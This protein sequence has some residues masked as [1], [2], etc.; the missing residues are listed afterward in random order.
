MVI[1]VVH[2]LAGSAAA[3]L[4][5]LAIIPEPIWAI[6]YLVLF[7]AGTIA[8]MMLITMSLATAF[9]YA[10]ARH[11]GWAAKLKIASGLVSI[12]FGLLLVY[13]IFVDGGFYSS[14]PTW[15]PQ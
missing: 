2:G 5:V 12:A 6:G 10:T 15:T 8:G 3:T 4:L 13:Q 1:G 14:H 9:Q 7:G 11:A